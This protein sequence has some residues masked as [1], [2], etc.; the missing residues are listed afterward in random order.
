MSARGAIVDRS[1]V[2]PAVAGEARAG[3]CGSARRAAAVYRGLTGWWPE[4]VSIHADDDFDRHVFASA[5]AVAASGGGA[6]ASR[7]GLSGVDFGRLVAVRFPGAGVLFAPDDGETAPADDEIAM[8]RAL[9]LASAS[10]DG[11][12]TAWLAAIVARRAIEPNH[13]WEDLGLR[14]RAELS[15]LLARHFA[16]LAARNTRNMR[17]K[18]FFYRTLCETDG[19]VLCATPVCTACGDFDLCFGEETGESRLARAR[20]GS[21]AP[22]S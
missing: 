8:V 3:V 18:R 4:E 9:L 16:P 17:W 5:I 13:L 20:R 11:E 6:V 22:L 14:D 7:L 19:I 1:A 12:D 10:R 15:R 2:P 21:A